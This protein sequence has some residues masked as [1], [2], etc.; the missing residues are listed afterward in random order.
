[1]KAFAGLLL[2]LAAVALA[3]E[4]ERF[5][6]V[7]SAAPDEHRAVL[8]SESPD[9]GP[10]LVAGYAAAGVLRGKKVHGAYLEWRG[11]PAWAALRPWA[12]VNVGEEGPYFVGAG[13]LYERDLDARWRLALSFGPG[14]YESNHRFELGSHL[15]FLSTIE[16]S[17]RLANGHRLSLAFGHISNGRVGRINPGSEFLKLAWQVP[18]RQPSSAARPVSSRHERSSD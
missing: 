7:D 3:G 9:Q 6:G 16:L 15:E 18:L 8:L 11:R 12:A 4:P 14:F 1:M 2:V 10:W 17:R 13:A 5:A